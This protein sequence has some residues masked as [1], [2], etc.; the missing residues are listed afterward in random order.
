MAAEASAA[1][2]DLESITLIVGD[3]DAATRFYAQTLGFSVVRVFPGDDAILETPGGVTFGLHVPHASHPPRV[4]TAGVEFGFVVDDVDA[5]HARLAAAGVTFT[6][7]PTDMPWGTR[8][9]QLADPDGHVLSLKARSAS[10]R[11]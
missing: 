6:R 2:A 3:L 7:A 4:E 5:W 11:A 9:A 1:R 8:E 10:G